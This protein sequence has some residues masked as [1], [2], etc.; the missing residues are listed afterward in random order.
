MVAGI[1]GRLGALPLAVHGIFMS[2]A[3]LFYLTANAI[4]LATSTI[5]GNHLGDVRI[6]THVLSLKFL[7]FNN[8]IDI[9][10]V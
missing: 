1:A 7:L 9:K 5:A 6:R 10:T 8:N 3:G 4:A 2:T